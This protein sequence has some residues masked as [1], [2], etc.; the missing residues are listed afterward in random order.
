[1]PLVGIPVHTKVAFGAG[2]AGEAV[3]LL[4]GRAA[5]SFFGVTEIIALILL[6]AGLGVG[7]SVLSL[8]YIEESP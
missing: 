8:V 3:Q 2:A 1:M 5:P 4:L 7:G 6:G